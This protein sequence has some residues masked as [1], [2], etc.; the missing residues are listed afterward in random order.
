MRYL[1]IIIFI[2]ISFYFGFWWGN[3]R[4]DNSV[5]W[6][7]GYCWG[8]VQGQFEGRMGMAYRH[9]LLEIIGIKQ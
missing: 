2:I 7:K 9:N 5:D 4:Y 3:F 1:L 6:M 8:Y